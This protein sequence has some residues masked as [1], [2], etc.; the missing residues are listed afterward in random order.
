VSSNSS[1]IRLNLL[2]RQLQ[3]T[4]S[5]FYDQFKEKIYFIDVV[6]VDNPNAR[7]ICSSGNPKRY[8]R[9]PGFYVP[10]ESWSQRGIVFRDGDILTMKQSKAINFAECNGGEV[11]VKYRATSTDNWFEFS[12]YHDVVLDDSK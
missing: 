4:G 6:A 7:R 12:Y 11:Y 8:G 9:A 1:W 2:E 10:M 3:P 5:D